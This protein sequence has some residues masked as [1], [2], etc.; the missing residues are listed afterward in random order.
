[1][2]CLIHSLPKDP[3]RRFRGLLLGAALTG[4]CLPALSQRIELLAGQPYQVSHQRTDSPVG[5]NA[6]FKEAHAL[7]YA[8]RV[9]WHG[10][11]EFKDGWLVADGPTVR[12]VSMAG[13]VRT[14]AEFKEQG[15]TIANFLL[16]AAIPGEGPWACCL[17]E[18][19]SHSLWRMD[20]D[21]RLAPWCGQFHG[22]HGDHS[23]DGPA[24]SASFSWVGGMVGDQDG[25]L[26]VVDGY[27]EWH[28]R[29]ITPDGHVTTLLTSAGLRGASGLALDEKGRTLYTLAGDRILAIAMDAPAVKPVLRLEAATF[30]G[31]LACHGG[32]LITRTS[33]SGLIEVDPR[34]GQARTLFLEARQKRLTPGPAGTG[35]L[36]ER[37]CLIASGQ[38]GQIATLSTNDQQLGL[39]LD[40][41]RPE[42]KKE[43]KDAAP[44][45]GP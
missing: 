28:V 35:S 31:G 6:L 42:E 2:R 15:G 20:A 39:L 21:G 12:W 25:N 30:R 27:R 37:R 45:E 26:Y 32:R 14:L 4:A 40:W 24:D 41:E 13:S 34:T 44:E 3:A 33:D 11:D 1:M 8:P 22:Q 38:A 18:E 16:V 43:R 29:R 19:F 7:A 17:W 23:L 5:R 9:P 10:K 36:G